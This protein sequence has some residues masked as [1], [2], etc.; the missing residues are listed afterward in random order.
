MHV[1]GCPV[2]VPLDRSSVSLSIAKSTEITDQL[3]WP[4]IFITCFLLGSLLIVSYC[5]YLNVTEER[6]LSGNYDWFTR[7]GR[8]LSMTADGG[9]LKRK[10]V[11]GPVAWIFSFIL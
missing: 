3:M 11:K 1:D 4:Y 10:M 5:I 7:D 2:A 8:D 6:P 9:K